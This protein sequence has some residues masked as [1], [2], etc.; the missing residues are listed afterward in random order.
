MLPGFPSCRGTPFQ[1]PPNIPFTSGLRGGD[2]ECPLMLSATG[3]CLLSL[4]SHDFPE[5]QSYSHKK[6]PPSCRFGSDMVVIDGYSSHEAVFGLLCT[7]FGVGRICTWPAAPEDWCES[8]DHQKLTAYWQCSIKISSNEGLSLTS[9]DLPV[10]PNPA[11]IQL[12]GRLGMD[13]AET[14]RS[15]CPTAG[16]LITILMCNVPTECWAKDSASL[17]GNVKGCSW[18]SLN[19]ED[20][21]LSL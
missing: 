21:C 13:M 6:E 17:I 15:P 19:W 20:L 9:W 7:C 8:P 3:L 16:L 10:T 5:E 4:L 2:W 14:V 12:G 11:P 18:P 1:D